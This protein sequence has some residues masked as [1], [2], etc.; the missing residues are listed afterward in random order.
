[1]K[2]RTVTYRTN[3]NL[4]N[5]RTKHVE[6]TAELDPKDKPDKALVKLA[7]WVHAQLGLPPV[8]NCCET[9]NLRNSFEDCR[10]K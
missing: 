3:V 2:I 4:G 1:M 7:N 6:A 10:G 9:A 8:S 5:Y